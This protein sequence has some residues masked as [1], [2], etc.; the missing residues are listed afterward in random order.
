MSKKYAPLNEQYKKRYYDE[1]G[2]PIALSPIDDRTQYTQITYPL[3]FTVNPSY[4][5]VAI[6]KTPTA[7]QIGRKAPDKQY[8]REDWNDLQTIR[9][10]NINN[11]KFNAIRDFL[12]YAGLEDYGTLIASAPKKRAE[13]ID[14]TTYNKLK[15]EEKWDVDQVRNYALN[16]L[17]KARD[18]GI[19]AYE[20]DKEEEILDNVINY[21]FRN[22]ARYLHDNRNPELNDA[23]KHSELT[24]KFWGKQSPDFK[25]KN[26]FKEFI[27]GII[28]QIM[29][30]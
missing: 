10:R 29:G 12:H 23:I 20:N 21:I 22:K 2:N 5:N 7:N 19:I 9:N 17:K 24:N 18:K 28:K 30:E 27:D 3:G 15:D 11:V 8:T 4:R 26:K 14:K 13:E 6:K 1:E 16:N 25:R